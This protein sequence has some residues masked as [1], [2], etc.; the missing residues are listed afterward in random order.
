M[1]T[2]SVCQF[3]RHSHGKTRFR[4]DKRKSQFTGCTLINLISQNGKINVLSKQSKSNC[5]LIKCVF[6]SCTKG[7]H[8]A[9]WRQ[10]FNRCWHERVYTD[11]TSFAAVN[12]RKKSIAPGLDLNPIRFHSSWNFLSKINCT[13][14]RSSEGEFLHQTAGIC[15]KIS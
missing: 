10:F 5:S 4:M 8:I 9:K 11:S 3:C 2:K 15:C 14:R 12:F 7:Y 6:L 13:M 1:I